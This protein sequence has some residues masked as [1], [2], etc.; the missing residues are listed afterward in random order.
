MRFLARESRH[1][2]TPAQALV[3][4]ATLLS[5][6]CVFDGLVT[7]DDSGFSH[8]P[9]RYGTLHGPSQLPV[10]GGGYRIPE[11]W[12]ERGLNYGVEELVSMLNYVGRSLEL[13]SQDL[14][15][16]VGDLSRPAGGSSPWHRSHQTGRDV[17]L[18]FFVRDAKGRRMVSDTMYKHDSQGHALAAGEGGAHSFDVQ[19]NWLLVAALIE[20]PIAEV[21]YIFIQDDLRHLLLEH[22]MQ[23]GAHRALLT[24]AFEVLRQARDS[25]PLDH[26]LHIRI[27]CPLVDLR[28]GSEDFGKL[29]WHKRDYKYA[30][31]IERLRRYDKLGA[32]AEAVAALP[33]L[34]R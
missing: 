6:A 30:R 13:Q 25:A 32:V 8:G 20:N 27:Y 11:R 5:S 23:I 22:A 31:R 28:S 12:S 4:V 24:R 1:R 2:P 29:R 34:W 17:D 19:A 10:Q 33:W 26:H 3:L 15:L 21:Q 16:S 7:A 9:S 14:V 18:L